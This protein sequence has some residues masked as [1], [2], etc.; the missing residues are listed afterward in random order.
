MTVVTEAD[1]TRAARDL[2]IQEGD[3]VLIHSSFKSMGHVEGGA[4]SVVLGFLNAL[5][6]EGTLVFPTLCQKDF[7]KAYETWHLDKESDVG[8]LTNYFRKRPGSFRS[9]QAT[10]S[11]AACGKYGRELTKTHGHTHKRF[12]NM[13]DTPF[14]A[15]SPWEKMYKMKAKVVL[16]G[17]APAYTTFRHY[18]EYCYVEECLNSIQEHPD[19]AKM[20]ARL[21]DFNKDG[22]WP[23]LKNQVLYDRLKEKGLTAECYCGDALLLSFSAADFVDLALNALRQHDEGVLWRTDAWDI[24]AWLAWAEDLRRMQQ[25][26]A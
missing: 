3:I 9:D 15:D 13:G 6:E 24:D 11:V 10:H 21:A 16:L 20:K 23:H 22:A 18:V 14:S 1:I 4:E 19:Y 7:E 2:N 25:E 26:N 12:G 5:G 8:Y 17:V